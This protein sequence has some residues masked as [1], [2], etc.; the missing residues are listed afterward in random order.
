LGVIYTNPD[1]PTFE[2]SMGV[3]AEDSRPLYE[4]GT[5]YEKL[6]KRIRSLI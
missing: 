2:D 6:L 3:Y 1:R 5:D 4:R